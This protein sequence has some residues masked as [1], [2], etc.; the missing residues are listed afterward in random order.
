MVA[1]NQSVCVDIVVLF[2][3]ELSTTFPHV[4]LLCTFVIGFAIGILWIAKESGTA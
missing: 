4:T 3:R 1:A 2:G